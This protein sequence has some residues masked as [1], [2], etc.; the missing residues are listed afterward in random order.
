[1]NPH[2]FTIPF[3]QDRLTRKANAVIFNAPD[4]RD[5]ALL[6]DELTFEQDDAEIYARLHAQGANLEPR[7]ETGKFERALVM[8]SKHSDFNKAM[9]GRAWSLVKDGGDIIVDGS[10][11]D[12]VDSIVRA[13]RSIGLTPEVEPKYHGKIAWFERRQDRVGGIKSWIDLDNPFQ[14]TGGFLVRP[15][16]FS[17][18]SVDKGTL[19][20][21]E[22][23]TMPIS[24]IV[25]DLGAGYGAIGRS[26]LENNPEIEALDLYEISYLA[27]ECAKTNVSDP[28]A[29]IHWLEVN[30]AAREYYNVIVS[31]PPFHRGQ[32]GDPNI[33]RSFIDAAARS[34]RARGSFYMVANRHLPYEHHLKARFGY[35][36]VMTENNAYK[37]FKATRPQGKNI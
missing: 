32:A 27:S 16:I 5:M 30:K 25:A 34:L 31:N 29:H 22:N 33:G 4:L 17:S 7:I 2:R 8:L 26:L 20:L 15:G 18:K 3:E 28:R 37:I 11:K 9:I 13:I 36:E 12:G 21:L 1:M 10:K 19:Y 35:V 14:N 6:G 24:G 23:L